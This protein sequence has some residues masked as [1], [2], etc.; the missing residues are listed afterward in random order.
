M[1]YFVIFMYIVHVL[2]ACTLA[3]LFMKC[4][5]LA[6]SWLF[7]CENTHI[8]PSVQLSKQSFYVL[9]LIL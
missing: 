6:S 2:A 7:S 1:Y 8:K 3:D 9:K 5:L 4:G